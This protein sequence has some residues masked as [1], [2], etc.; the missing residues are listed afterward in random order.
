AHDAANSFA[1]YEKLTVTIK[2]TATAVTIA[3]PKAGF[4]YVDFFIEFAGP[5]KPLDDAGAVALANVLPDTQGE[6][7]VE[8]VRMIFV[9]GTPPALRLVQHPPQPG[10][11]WHVLGIPRVSLNAISAFVTAGGSSASARKLPYEMIIVGVE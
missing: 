4:N 6:P 3:S 10:D 1:S 8:N 11:R 7:I 2:A 9:P 5:P